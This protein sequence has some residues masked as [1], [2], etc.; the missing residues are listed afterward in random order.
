VYLTTDG[1]GVFRS[2]D[3]GSTWQRIDDPKQPDMQNAAGI[4]IATHPQ[5]M[6]FVVAKGSFRSLD[7]GSTWERATFPDNSG[8]V[9]S[10]FLDGDSTRL[11]SANWSGLW[12][13]SNAGDTWE[14]AA[15]VL[16]RLHATALG[17]ATADGHAI[18]YAATCG[19]DP[20]VTTTA[21]GASRTVRTTARKLV[22]AGIY[23]YVL[24]SAP[25]VTLKLSGLKKGALKLGKRL[26]VTGKVTPATLAGSKV[27]LKVQKKKANKWVTVKTVQRT[28]SAKGAYS[29]RYK[30]GKKGAYRLQATLA[31]TGTHTGAKTKWRSFKVK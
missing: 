18:V 29:W 25:R 12:S 1:T 5:P 14:R 9:T 24:L 23:R 13:S 28:V 11:Y 2:T 8:M 27:T 17:S 15:G 16:G 22:D 21:A 7:G 10:L 19:G 30:L 31:K 3:G 26:T 4:T 6:L 20:G